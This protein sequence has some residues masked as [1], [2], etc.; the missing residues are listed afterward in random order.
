VKGNSFR[1][2]HTVL[3]QRSSYSAY[4]PNPL[5]RRPADLVRFVILQNIAADVLNRRSY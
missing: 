2:S 4:R 3:K 5:S 1:H